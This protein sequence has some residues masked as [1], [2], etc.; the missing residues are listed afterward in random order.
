M[1]LLDTL[2]AGIAG[3]ASLEAEVSR[4][5]LAP[6]GQVAQGGS[7]VPLWGTPASAPPLQAA[8]INGIAAHAF[9]L[10]DSGGCDHSGAVVVPA[11][12]A[13]IALAEGPVTG[14]RL[15]LAVIAGYEL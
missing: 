13:A 12:L 9:E 3:S 2:G 10:D 11:A 15:V 6:T 4:L 1:H 7:G 5:A 14:E 8:F